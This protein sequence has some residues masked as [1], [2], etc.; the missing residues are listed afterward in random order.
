[1]WGPY[2]GYTQIVIIKAKNKL[3]NSL[4]SPTSP[5]SSTSSTSSTTSSK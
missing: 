3:S 1:M 4:E 5:T 2:Y